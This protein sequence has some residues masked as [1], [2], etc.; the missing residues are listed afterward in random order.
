MDSSSHQFLP[1]CEQR[2]EWAALFHFV[3][4]IAFPDR[5][6]VL[7]GFVI[8]IETLVVVITECQP[9]KEAVSVTDT[10]ANEEQWCPEA[11]NGCYGMG[12]DLKSCEEGLDMMRC[13]FS[14]TEGAEAFNELIP[15]AVSDGLFQSYFSAW[16]LCDVPT[17]LENCT[18]PTGPEG[19]G[20]EDMQCDQIKSYLNCGAESAG[21][22]LDDEQKSVVDEVVEALTECEGQM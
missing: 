11:C 10:G 5:S 22:K 15:S 9:S 12:V 17:A 21:I 6:S 2:G 19:E 8:A 20:T 18:A 4:Q 1:P 14:N 16:S 7:F 3:P 13:V